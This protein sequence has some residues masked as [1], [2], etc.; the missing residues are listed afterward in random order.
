MV[1]I[2][3]QTD[4][5]DLPELYI[6]YD[7]RDCQTVLICE[8]LNKKSLVHY[9]MLTCYSLALFHVPLLGIVAR[10]YQNYF[11]HT[12]T[13]RCLNLSALNLFKIFYLSYNIATIC[14]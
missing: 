7:W 3:E 10:V 6:R 2:A 14:I 9:N 5:I 8:I 1:N 11:R 13:R 12:R 4:G